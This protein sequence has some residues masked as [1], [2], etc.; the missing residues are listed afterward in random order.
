MRKAV[1]DTEKYLKKILYLS[2]VAHVESF[3][4]QFFIA[5]IN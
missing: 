5:L 3:T 4:L 1:Q 2:T